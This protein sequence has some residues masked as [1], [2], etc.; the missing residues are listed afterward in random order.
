M[1]EL[2]AIRDG[3]ALDL[4]KLLS[5]E[6]A[7]GK[8]ASFPALA[9]AFAEFRFIHS[10]FRPAHDPELH[11]L[12]TRLCTWADQGVGIEAILAYMHGFMAKHASFSAPW[13]FYDQ[14]L[15]QR[16]VLSALY[17]QGVSSG[18]P[19]PLRPAL[20]TPR[21]LRPRRRVAKAS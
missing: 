10:L 2:L 13:D 7:S 11:V 5:P 16:F 12:W 15:A 20:P 3:K 17:G 8:I 6:F 1:T 14:D 9:A 21:V 19:L 4:A 18:A